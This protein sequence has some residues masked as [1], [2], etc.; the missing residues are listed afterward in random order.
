MKG[1]HLPICI[2]L[3]AILISPSL[4]G[5]PANLVEIPPDDFQ[6]TTTG[7]A[8]NTDD[9]SGFPD[10]A[11]NATNNEYFVVFERDLAV[12]STNTEVEIAGQ[13]INASTGALNGGPIRISDMGS[14]GA[15]EFDAFDPRVV[16]NATNNEYLV[17]W[18]GDDDTGALIDE[19]YEIYGQRINA[20]TGA[21]VG[22]N[23]FR[24]SQTGVDGNQLVDAFDPYAVWN[25]TANEYLVVWDADATDATFEIFGQR[26]SATGAE[27]GSND[28]QISDIGATT[29]DGAFFPTA[30]WNATENE[31]LVAWEADPGT[32][33]LGAEEVEIFGQLLD[34]TG[35]EIGPDD[36][37]ISDL[38]AD[39][40]TSFNAF[41][42]SVAWSDSANEYMVV[43]VG[44]DNTGGLVDGQF[45]IFGQRVSADGAPVG[46]NDFRISDSQPAGNAAADSFDAEIV[47]NSTLNEY[48]VTWEGEDVTGPILTGL[49]NEPHFFEIYVQRLN[50]DGSEPEQEMIISE[51]GDEDDPLVDAISP[52][53]AWNSTENEYLVAWDGDDTGTDGAFE[54]FGQLLGFGAG[55][56]S[57]ATTWSGY[58]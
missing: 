14:D 15:V 58:Q 5:T 52:V 35:T 12:G 11:Y 18:W 30:A 1:F 23:D 54:V 48:L 56:A 17:V 39:G 50:P 20:A 13:R 45:Q 33:G 57:G 7:P 32:G 37:R 44:D 24:I 19:E 4:A 53:V 25:A 22:T 3:S 55:A 6:I 38:G 26:L 42:P 47:W 41:L 10:V 40:N 21:Q 34:S 28:F 49:E 51:S 46:T 29:G 2:A 8:G 9:Y 36:F 43:F 16:W 27:I 31:Y